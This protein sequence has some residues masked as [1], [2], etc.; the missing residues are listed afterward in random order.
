MADIGSDG[1][2]KLENPLLD[3]EGRPL[4]L[5]FSLLSAASRHILKNCIGS[6]LIDATSMLNHKGHHRVWMH[7]TILGMPAPHTSRFG[8]TGKDVFCFSAIDFLAQVHKV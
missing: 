7:I 3:Q 2:K 1:R 6:L 5:V 4:A 8:N